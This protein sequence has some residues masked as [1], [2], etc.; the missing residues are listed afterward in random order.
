VRYMAFT[1]AVNRSL[2]EGVATDVEGGE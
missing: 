1:E 2:E